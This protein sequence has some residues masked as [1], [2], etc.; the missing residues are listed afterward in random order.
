MHVS[1]DTW[2]DYRDAVVWCLIQHCWKDPWENGSI[3]RNIF[4]VCFQRTRLTFMSAA[5]CNFKKNC[6]WKMYQGS[7]LAVLVAVRRLSDLSRVISQS[8]GLQ[9]DLSV[10][11]NRAKGVIW[12]CVE[13]LSQ[14]RHHMYSPC[15]VFSSVL[16]VKHTHCEAVF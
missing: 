9:G 13:Y 7:S 3:F 10:R 1:E 6:H 14:S 2:E 16:A 8:F 15:R 11:I 4:F 5:S 12:E